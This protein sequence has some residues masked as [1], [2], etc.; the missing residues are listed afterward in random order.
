LPAT[1]LAAAVTPLSEAAA[2]LVW[3]VSEAVG[4]GGAAL[5]AGVGGD[6]IYCES[7]AMAAAMALGSVLPLSSGVFVSSVAGCVSED[8]SAAGAAALGSPFAPALDCASSCRKLGAS[9][10]ACVAADPLEPAGLAEAAV[11]FGSPAPPVLLG[12][13]APTAPLLAELDRPP[14]PLDRPSAPLDGL[15]APLERPL[16]PW[17]GP[18]AP[19]DGPLAPLDRVVPLDAAGVLGAAAAPLDLRAAVPG[20]VPEAEPVFWAPPP[21]RAA[22]PPPEPRDEGA[23]PAEAA[24]EEETDLRATPM[25]S[26][27]WAAL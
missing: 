24:G 23:A 18:L 2:A 15:L 8:F 1:T 19:L 13:P 9:P 6:A 21:S 14:A 4:C 3:A 12:P 7:S 11:P 26:V 27:R 20:V 25:H 17:Q 16:A 22:I 5:A 10:G